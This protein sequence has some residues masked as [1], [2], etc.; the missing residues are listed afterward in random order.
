MRAP[1]IKSS[2]QAYQVSLAPKSAIISSK[3]VDSKSEAL[4]ETK[5]MREK[6]LEKREKDKNKERYKRKDRER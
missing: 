3:T 1:V 2:S 4:F 6:E 5:T